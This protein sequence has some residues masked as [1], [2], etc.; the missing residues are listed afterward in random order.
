MHASCTCA[1]MQQP[2]GA[3]TVRVCSLNMAHALH[4]LHTHACCVSS[5]MLFKTILGV[6]A[7]HIIM[8]NTCVYYHG[9]NKIKEHN[10]K[11]KFNLMEVEQFLSLP[12]DLEVYKGALIIIYMY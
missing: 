5:Y 4:S 3:H 1:C 7:S 8:S 11:L 12:L 6:L 10:I 2:N 9:N